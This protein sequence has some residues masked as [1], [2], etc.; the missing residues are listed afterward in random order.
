MAT[1]GAASATG[2]GA[3]SGGVASGGLSNDAGSGGQTGAGGATGGSSTDGSGGD[4]VEATG[5]QPNLEQLAAGLDELF[6]HDA[7]TGVQGQSDT[8]THVQ[9]IEETITMGGD[10]N[11]S[12]VVTLRVRGL[13]EPTNISGGMAPLAEHPYFVTGGTVNAADYSQW[14]IEVQQPPEVYTLNHYPQTS[15]TIYQQDFEAPIVIAGGS[16]VVV[17]VVD[18]NDRQIDN[19]TEGLPDRRQQIEGVTDGVLDGQVLR[20]DVVRVEEQV[21]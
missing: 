20:L 2:G 6:I 16:E 5:G 4:A 8:C 14:Q 1:G 11:A 9:R 13:F 19:G 15:H 12:Y 3:A 17:R 7:C 21:P 10:A 18:G